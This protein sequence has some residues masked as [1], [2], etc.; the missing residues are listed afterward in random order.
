MSTLAQFRTAIA[1]KIGLD[2][3]TSGDQG[4]IDLWVNEGVTD[5]LMRT[6]CKVQSA[7]LNLTADTGDYTVDT[8]VL[9]IVKATTTSQSVSYDLQQVPADDIL[10]MR[11]ASSTSISPAQ[12]YAMLGSD[13]FMIYPTPSSSTD[14]V[15]FYYV[16][17]PAT[18]SASSDSPDEVPAEF[19]KA[20]EFYALAE[21]GN[22]ADDGTAQQGLMYLQVYEQWIKRIK[23]W[24][25][26]KGGHRL[27]FA[28]VTTS[29]GIRPF[30]DRS[31]YPG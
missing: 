6:N 28:T 19:H 29:H 8:D 18:L 17:R 11:N 15:T 9:K 7:D 23:K 3:S 25:G 24:V 2:N 20:I 22:Y 26:L 14:T 21:A 10:A 5:V 16:P 1:A 4:A 30:H 12:Y 27:P 13:L 31:R